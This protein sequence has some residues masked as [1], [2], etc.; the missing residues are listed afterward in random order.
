MLFTHPGTRHV[1]KTTLPELWGFLC[2]PLYFALHGN[3][4]HA[5]IAF[6][7]V[8]MTFGLAGFVYLFIARGIIRDHYKRIGYHGGGDPLLNKNV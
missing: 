5:F 8:P 6:F 7:L 1:A 3:W 2:A 4:R